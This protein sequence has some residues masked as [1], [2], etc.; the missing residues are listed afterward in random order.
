MVGTPI[1]K[2]I[3]ALVA[4]S[5]VIFWDSS[6]IESVTPV[7]NSGALI[8]ISIAFPVLPPMRVSPQSLGGEQ[9]STITST[10]LTTNVP[11]AFSAKSVEVE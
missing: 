8:A 3:I 9:Y 2:I 1:P 4:P 10:G 7:T 5:S 11:T 6:N